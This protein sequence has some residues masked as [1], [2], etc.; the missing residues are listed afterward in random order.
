M[1]SCQMTGKFPREEKVV[2]RR[3]KKKF[4][5]KFSIGKRID[6]LENFSQR[7][8]DRKRKFEKRAQ[9]ELAESKKVE[10]QTRKRMIEEDY[11]KA[12]EAARANYHIEGRSE[13]V[14]VAEGGTG[15]EEENIRFDETLDE[16][17]NVN[18]HITPLESPQFRL[19]VDLDSIQLPVRK[20][21]IKVDK[22]PFKAAT[23][24]PKN[25]FRKSSRKGSKGGAG[26]GKGGKGSQGGRGG[27]MKSVRKGK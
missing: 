8:T 22:K 19:N 16:F 6:F 7:K 18:V 5:V 9:A 2:F 11:K 10:K 3:E 23:R 13:G 24:K 17:D 26:R 14:S 21:P 27:N 20:E 15:I 12:V 25:V 1:Q 4:E